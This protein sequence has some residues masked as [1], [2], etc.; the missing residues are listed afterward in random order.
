MFSRLF[1]KKTCTHMD[2]LEPVEPK[3]PDSC[4]SCV[5][6]GDTWVNLRLCLTCGHVGCCDNSKNQHASKHAAENWTPDH[7]VVPAGR[8]VAVLLPARSEATRRGPTGA[9]LTGGRLP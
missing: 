5:E 9:Q 8:K 4:L 1:G 2:A 3:S 7:P 6:M